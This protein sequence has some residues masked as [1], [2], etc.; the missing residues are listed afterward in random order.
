MARMTILERRRQRKQQ[1]D[2]CTKWGVEYKEANPRASEEDVRSHVQGKAR[3]AG[4]DW[5]TIVQAVFAALAAI[6]GKK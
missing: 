3:E 4:F 5:L 2:Q 6:F 1:I